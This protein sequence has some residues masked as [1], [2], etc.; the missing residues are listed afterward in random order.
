M[1]AAEKHNELAV[2]FVRKVGHGTDKASEIAVVLETIILGSM[3]L[4]SGLHGASPRV[5]SGMVEAAVQRALE[6]FTGS[7]TN[8]R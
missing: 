7:E 3:R 1:S 8:A 5:A 4:M 6:R 2:E